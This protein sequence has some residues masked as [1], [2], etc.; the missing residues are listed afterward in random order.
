MRRCIILLFFV[1]LMGGNVFAQRTSVIDDN[2]KVAVLWVV[3][4]MKENLK[5]SDEQASAFKSMVEEKQAKGEDLIRYD[6]EQLA[7]ILTPDQLSKIKNEN[8]IQQKSF[9]DEMARNVLNSIATA[10]EVYA[11][12]HN[13]KYPVGIASLTNATPP[14]LSSSRCGTTSDGY[15]FT[16]TFTSTDY[17]IQATPVAVGVSGTTT[18]TVKT[19]GFVTP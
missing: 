18:Y 12:V 3:Q 6:Q 17:M 15:T 2:A 11:K 1:V 7:R 9:R 4:S 13:G 19:G 16:C 14:Y 8:A 10:S 5:L